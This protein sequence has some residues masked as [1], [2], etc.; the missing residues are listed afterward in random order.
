VVSVALAVGIALAA[1]IGYPIARAQATGLPVG[2]FVAVSLVFVVSTIVQ[3]S[4]A[5]TFLRRQAHAWKCG[6]TDA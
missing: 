4:A 2:Y 3:Q 5:E 1:V 6:G